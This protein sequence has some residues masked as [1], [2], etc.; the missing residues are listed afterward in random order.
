MKWEK[1]PTSLFFGC[2]FLPHGKKK[3][4]ICIK[5]FCEKEVPKLPNFKVE[6]LRQ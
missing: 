2:N 3:S 5:D 4:A 1:D 6:R